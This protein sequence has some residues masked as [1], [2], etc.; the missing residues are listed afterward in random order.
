MVSLK[1]TIII[2]I[3]SAIISTIIGTISAIGISNMKRI[4]RGIVMNISYLPVLN[5]D[6]IT[7]VSLM[8]LFIFANM[9][10]GFTTML[11]AHITFNIPYVI[12]SVMPKIKQ[13]DPHIYEAALDLGASPTY[14]FWK[15]ILPQLMPGIVTGFMLAFTLSIDDFVIS[16]F[17]TGVGVPNLSIT[18]FSMAR[19]GVNPKINALSTLMFMSVLILLVIVNIRMSRDMK[20]KKPKEGA[21]I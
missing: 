14:A 16:F 10:F 19:R 8:I 4:P 12:L 17:T 5:P 18:V 20:A 6:I 9:T 1:Y 11:I 13:L 2:A 7:G 21:L 15:V 3:L